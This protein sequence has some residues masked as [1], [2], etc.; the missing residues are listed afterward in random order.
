MDHT[1]V[2]PSTQSGA[3][4]LSALAHGRGTSPFQYDERQLG[5]WVPDSWKYVFDFVVEPDIV[6]QL[7]ARAVK[8]V[9]HATGIADINFDYYGVRIT[10]LPRATDGTAMSSASLFEWIRTNLNAVVNTVITSFDPWQS[11]DAATWGSAKPV[12]AVM[13]LKVNLFVDFMK[14]RKILGHYFTRDEA[15]VCCSAY[16]AGEYWIFTTVYGENSFKG[17]PV[18]GNRLFRLRTLEDG[19]FVFYTRGADRLT[20]L[21]DS[22]GS[23]GGTVAFFGADKL[24]RSLQ[25]GLCTYVTRNGGAAHVIPPISE[26]YPYQACADKLAKMQPATNVN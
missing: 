12:G 9:Y 26:R 19:T 5:G 17:H 8:P 1:A 7:A 16:K 20:R 25:E 23:G 22:T 15:G 13:D 10:A 4:D 3:S 11:A 6:A 21:L 2:P 18:S 24:W 14:M